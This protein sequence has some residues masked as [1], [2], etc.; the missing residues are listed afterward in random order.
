MSRL[1][2]FILAFALF[3]SVTFT[4]ASPVCD[5]NEE[6]V[7]NIGKRDTRTGRV[8]SYLFSSLTYP[9]HHTLQQGHWVLSWFG[10]FI[11]FTRERED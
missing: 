5:V 8:T 10:T 2:L 4:F 3:A 9:N 11:I 6:L 1:A 7:D